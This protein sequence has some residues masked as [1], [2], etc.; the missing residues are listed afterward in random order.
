MNQNKFV[1]NNKEYDISDLSVLKNYKPEMLKTEPYPYIVIENC[2]DPE[3]YDY[4][5]KNYP[6]DKTIAGDMEK[7]NA[8]YQLKVSNT[9][10][11]ENVDEIWK[12]FTEYHTTEKFYREVENIFGD[13][14]I[15]S[16]FVGEQKRFKNFKNYNK[17]TI[18]KRIPPKKRWQKK[19]VMDTQIGINSPTTEKTQV[20]RPHT[21]SKREIYAGLFYLKHDDDNGLGGDLNILNLKKEYNNIEE[22][23]KIIGTRKDRFFDD[24]K[25]KLKI[26]DTV[27]YDKNK[28]VLFVN[29]DNAIHEVTPR[30]PN[31]LS[32]RLVNIIGEHYM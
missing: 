20:I 18:N 22:F 31:K 5:E 3:I 29:Y 8:R 1:I 11:N 6:S 26:I 9:I 21:D 7:E 23:R 17:I 32:R 25:E 24:F 30:E 12:M 15:K 13:S 4:L 10:D 14:T 28:L 19:I 27:K 2:L 16:L